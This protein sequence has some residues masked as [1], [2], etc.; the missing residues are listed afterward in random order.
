MPVTIRP[1]GNASVAFAGRRYKQADSPNEFLLRTL[2]DE[3]GNGPQKAPNI[4]ASD[5]TAPLAGFDETN[6]TED[7]DGGEAVCFA[8]KNGLVHTCLEA[9]NTHHRLVLRPEDVWFAILTQF[10]SYINGHVESDVELRETFI[11]PDSE[12]NRDED[13]KIKKKELHVEVKLMDDTDHGH[14]AYRMGKLIQ[15]NIRDEGLRDWILPAFTTTHKVDQAV[16][17]MLLMGA[18]QKFFAFSWGTRCGLPS[19][20]LLGEQSDWAKMRRR[21][22]RLSQYGEEPTRWL[23]LLR[24]ILDGFVH[25]FEDPASKKTLKFWGNICDEFRPNG[26]GCTTYSGW[27]TAF[28]FWDAEGKCLH[29]KVAS[30][31]PRFSLGR[32]L[33][34]PWKKGVHL[35]RGDV[36]VGFCKVPVTLLYNGVE[37]PSEIIAG[38]MG[39]RTF[40]ERGDGDERAAERESGL[41]TTQPLA[42]WFLYHK[43][44]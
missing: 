12:D 42:G 28:C 7:A 21:I 37:V 17:S 26:S 29:N 44:T 24:P 16:A 5:F 36:P 11:G 18:T 9:Y 4:V 39:I 31:P 1:S 22:E 8:T 34:K 27:I 38:S 19:V 20:T 43:D 25:S 30:E 41:D 23:G 15:E 2:Q 32:P 3:L 14:I 40:R 13:G 10:A 33:L 6:E 35:S